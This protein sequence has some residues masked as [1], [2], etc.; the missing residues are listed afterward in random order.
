MNLSDYPNI[1]KHPM[2][3]ST[4]ELN[5]KQGKYKLVE[6]FLDHIQL[7]WDNCKAYNMAGS[8]PN[9]KHAV[10]LRSC[11]KNIKN[12]QENDQKLLP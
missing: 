11:L 7:I 10:D 8:V 6:E 9:H 2:D 3:L 5:L 4:V 1:I 12:I